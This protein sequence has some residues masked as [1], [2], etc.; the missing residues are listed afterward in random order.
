MGPTQPILL[1]AQLLGGVATG[2]RD[3][4]GHGARGIDVA[5]WTV[6]GQQG[7]RPPHRLGPVGTPIEHLVALVTGPQAHDDA[8]LEMC[9]R[10]RV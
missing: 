3:E 10:D 8:S 4:T 9:I 1:G 5:V 2:C 6:R 7:D